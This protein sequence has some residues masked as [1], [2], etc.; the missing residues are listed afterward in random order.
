MTLDEE[1]WY[2]PLDMVDYAVEGLGVGLNEH[3]Y[4]QYLQEHAASAAL[5]IRFEMGQNL[6]PGMREVFDPRPGSAAYAVRRDLIEAIEVLSYNV[7]RLQVEQTTMRNAL[8]EISNTLRNAATRNTT[9]PQELIKIIERLADASERA[10]VGVR[11]VA[12]G[13]GADEPAA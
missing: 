6:A 12:E 9:K 8:H 13:S 1:A 5:G 3:S 10:A 2:V 11:R 4:R 7:V